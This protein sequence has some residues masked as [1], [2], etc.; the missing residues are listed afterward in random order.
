MWGSTKPGTAIRPSASSVRMEVG[1]TPLRFMLTKRPLAIPR[2]QKP[3]VPHRATFF[4]RIS[5]VI[6]GLRAERAAQLPIAWEYLT[7]KALQEKLQSAFATQIS[8]FDGLALP[9]FGE[10]PEGLSFNGDAEYERRGPDSARPLRRCRR[11]LA[12]RPLPLVSRARIGRTIECFARRNGSRMS[13]W[14]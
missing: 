11:G 3:S 13:F 9:A 12:K 8:D 2:S 6:D 4:T 5:S 14:L 7:A 10:A 1:D